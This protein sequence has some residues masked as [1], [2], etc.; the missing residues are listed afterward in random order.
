MLKTQEVFIQE[1]KLLFSNDNCWHK[2]FFSL[3]KSQTNFNTKYLFQIAKW[4]IDNLETFGNWQQITPNVH[5]GILVPIPFFHLQLL[6]Y[7]TMFFCKLLRKNPFTT[8]QTFVYNLF[9]L[10]NILCLKLKHQSHTYKIFHKFFLKKIQNT[11]T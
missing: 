8:Q 1:S 4:E 5:F 9:I 6:Y 11:N 2:Y 10:F 7:A 3:K